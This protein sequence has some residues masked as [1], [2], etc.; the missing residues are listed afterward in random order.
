MRSALVEDIAQAVQVPCL[1]YTLVMEA[2]AHT[3]DWE[4]VM[5][6]VEVEELA[7]MEEGAEVEVVKCNMVRLFL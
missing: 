7:V 4:A 5:E 3:T 2:G 1:T 6:V